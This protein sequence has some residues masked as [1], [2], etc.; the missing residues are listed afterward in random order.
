MFIKYPD[1]VKYYPD[2]YKTSG[3]W[4]PS[5]AHI[6]NKCS[7]YLLITDKKIP[8]PEEDPSLVEGKKIH[9]KAEDILT[10]FLE[11]KISERVALS[12][13]GPDLHNYLKH[14]LIHLVSRKQMETIG[15]ESI[16][17]SVFGSTGIAGIPDFFSIT[18]FDNHLYTMKIVDLKFRKIPDDM[19]Q[20][21]LYALLISDTFKIPI[22][23]ILKVDV[24]YF[25]IDNQFCHEE[26]D[27][28]KLLSFKSE[29]VS[30]FLGH[31][32]L[33]FNPS[34]ELCG[35]CYRKSGCKKGTDIILS[36]LQKEIDG[37][38]QPSP[39]PQTLAKLK[40]IAG[41]ANKL[42]KDAEKSIE[43]QIKT[44]PEDMH[45]YITVSTRGKKVWKMPATAFKLFPPKEP[46]SPAQAIKEHGEKKVKPLIDIVTST[47]FNF[48][49]KQTANEKKKL[50]KYLLE[51]KKED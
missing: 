51:N 10:D 44:M 3:M 8:H 33:K 21:L 15:V 23:N 6:W 34:L 49:N 36:G 30:M 38:E 13:G 48:T 40:T 29:L 19:D 9:K 4:N 26:I 45:K 25:T 47:F 43:S 11:E 5:A 16:V 46:M 20:L 37:L 24:S 17:G 27:Q 2:Q 50:E 22:S 14:I 1:H 42:I 28:W 35:K 39:S 12:R 32:P 18:P 41:A 7:G 31:A